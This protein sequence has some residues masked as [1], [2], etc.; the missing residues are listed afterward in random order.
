MYYI[1]YDSHLIMQILGKYKK[2]RP[3]CIA[4]NMDKYITVSIGNLQFVDSLQFMNCSLEKLVAN[5]SQVGVDQFKTLKR[6]YSDPDKLSLLLR[7][8]IYPYDY[9]DNEDRFDETSLP[10]EEAFYTNVVS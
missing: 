9:I 6:H 7:K 2:A 10:S 1:S 8:G 5:L 4:Q 3:K